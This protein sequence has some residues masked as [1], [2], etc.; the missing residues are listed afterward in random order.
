MF[1]IK[2]TDTEMGSDQTRSSPCSSSCN[3]CEGRLN[4]QFVFQ[5][6]PKYALS[7]S[8]MKIQL[9]IILSSNRDPQGSPE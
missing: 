1:P 9:I 6:S 3:D 2:L 5:C 4:R 7:Q 8:S